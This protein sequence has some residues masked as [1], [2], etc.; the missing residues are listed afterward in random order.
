MWMWR[1]SW[2]PPSSAASG[3]AP[4]ALDVHRLRARAMSCHVYHGI[5][6]A[7]RPLCNLGWKRDPQS[8]DGALCFC[9]SLIQR[10]VML[11]WA[12][13]AWRAFSAGWGY[14][15]SWHKD[16]NGGFV[17]NAETCQA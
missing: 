6:Q 9:H 3:E 4:D 16:L 11:N 8:T 13:K 7:V 12:L 15:D 17:A 1:L 14:E 5:A 2:S 10:L